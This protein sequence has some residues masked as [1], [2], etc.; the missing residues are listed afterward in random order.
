[1]ATWDKIM[2]PPA[3]LA[4]LPV[5]AAGLLG[6]PLGDSSADLCNG[7]TNASP[8]VQEGAIGISPHCGETPSHHIFMAKT[9]WL[10]IFFMRER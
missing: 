7:Q 4:F 6:V 10:P 1:M 9:F 5:K 2:K 8:R 3:F